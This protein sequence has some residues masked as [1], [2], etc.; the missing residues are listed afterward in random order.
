MRYQNITGR[1]DRLSCA[2]NKICR[3]KGW[4]ARLQCEG[5]DISRQCWP[6]LKSDATEIS[7]DFLP[8]FPA[9]LGHSHRPVFPTGSSRIRRDAK[10]A[11]PPLPGPTS[12]NPFTKC[13]K[14][15][16]QPKQV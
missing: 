15:T 9:R 14:L 12:K 13:Q 6:T 1:R 10:L 7:D 3:R 2:P 4:R 5:L 11:A 16:K 8:L